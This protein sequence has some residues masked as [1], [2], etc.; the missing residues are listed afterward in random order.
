MIRKIDNLGRVVIPKEIRKQHS[1]REGDTV[2]FFNVSNGVFVTKFESLF[3]P[4]CESLVRSTDKYCSECGTK[5]TSEQDEN[6]EEEKW[7]K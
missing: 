4:I 1:M 3:C 5:L 6:G 2:K 7:V